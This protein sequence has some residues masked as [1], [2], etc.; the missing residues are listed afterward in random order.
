MKR[1][2]EST[3]GPAYEAAYDGARLRT[4]TEIIRDVMLSAAECATWLTLRE[5]ELLTYFPQ[6]SI[7]AQLRHL[8]KRSFGGWAV[9]KRRR[10]PAATGLWEYRVL[11]PGVAAAQREVL[12]VARAAE[13]ELSATPRAI[14]DTAESELSGVASHV[15]S[16]RTPTGYAGARNPSA[17]W[18][19]GPVK[20]HREIPRC[21]RNDNLSFGT[22][23]CPAQWEPSGSLPAIVRPAP[24]SRSL[25]PH[26]GTGATK[27]GL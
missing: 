12:G 5:I 6:A 27:A 4:Q 15:P 11:S 25:V 26:S 10:G 13:S 16:F 14:P 19:D 17:V 7:S 22:T 1:R 23:I 8:R 9:E 24:R 21:A 3:Y 18:S 2:R 20:D